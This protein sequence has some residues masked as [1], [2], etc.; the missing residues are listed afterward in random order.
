M[1]Y[2]LGEDLIIVGSLLFLSVLTRRLHNR[3]DAPITD[4]LGDFAPNLEKNKVGAIFS[5]V[6]I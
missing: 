1:V 2:E 5:H 3:V 4:H 6:G